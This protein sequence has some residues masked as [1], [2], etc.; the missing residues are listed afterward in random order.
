MIE[1]IRCLEEENNA[2]KA[3]TQAESTLQTI[4]DKLSTEL[5]TKNKEVLSLEELVKSL[6]RE[7][8]EAMHMDKDGFESLLDYHRK[9]ANDSFRSLSKRLHTDLRM[10]DIKIKELQ[11][12]ITKLKKKV[13]QIQ[14]TNPPTP[15]SP[16]HCSPIQLSNRFNKLQEQD[17]VTI[18]LTRRYQ[19]EEV[20]PQ[21]KLNQSQNQGV[22]NTSNRIRKRR[23][24]RLTKIPR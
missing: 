13:I 23:T 5:K 24:H 16:H 6:R 11:S 14:L 15:A 18:F 19:I 3:N 9:Y 22:L 17:D 1:S 20:K 7:L 10:H 8:S 2:L 12:E 21:R 4:V